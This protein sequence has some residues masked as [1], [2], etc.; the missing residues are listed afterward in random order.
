MGHNSLINIQHICMERNDVFLD[1]PLILSSI[2]M[3]RT[4]FSAFDHDART[5]FCFDALV[6]VADHI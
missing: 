2:I 3:P 6:L 5:E 1:S 4:Q